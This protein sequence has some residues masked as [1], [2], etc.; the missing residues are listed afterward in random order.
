MD[1][2]IQ[3]YCAYLRQKKQTTQHAEISGS[4]ECFTFHIES[5][6]L[7]ENVN[8]AY[9]NAV[10]VVSGGIFMEKAEK[11]CDEDSESTRLEGFIEH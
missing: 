9:L 3:A 4:S 10:K 1:A 2:S 11:N 8:T 6:L 7:G 5:S